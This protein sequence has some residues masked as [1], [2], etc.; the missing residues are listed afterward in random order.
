MNIITSIPMREDRRWVA[1][2]FSSSREGWPIEGRTPAHPP[3]FPFSRRVAKIVEGKTLYLVYRNN[4]VGYAKIQTHEEIRQGKDS[5]GLR[6]EDVGPGDHLIL[7]SALK[8]MPTLIPCVGFRNFRYLSEN[9]HALEPKVARKVLKNLGL[10]SPSP[11]ETQRGNHFDPRT[12][13]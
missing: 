9:L 1:A 8:P 7:R 4:V 5:V 11:R 3:V 13:R 10:T 12:Y 2:L 6:P